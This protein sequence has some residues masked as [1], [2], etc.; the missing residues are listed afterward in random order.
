MSYIIIAS[1]SFLNQLNISFNS[2]NTQTIII[3][4][5]LQQNQTNYTNMYNAIYAWLN[6]TFPQQSTGI[7]TTIS[8]PGL[9]IQVIDPDGTTA[10]DSS[11][12]VNNTYNNYLSKTIYE[13]Q[14]TRSYNIGAIMSNAGV[15][16]QTKYSQSV[17]AF[18][19]YL[20]VRLGLGSDVPVGNLV[21]S[22]DTQ[23]GI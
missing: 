9:R 14:N 8:I 19:M 21:I 1:P 15:F 11:K 13:N 3:A 16:Y 17:K 7:N 20:A 18:Q 12:G 5:L 2:K 23:V 4:F 6:S 10:F 22:M